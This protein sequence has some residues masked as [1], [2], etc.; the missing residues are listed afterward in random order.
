MRHGMFWCACVCSADHADEY[1]RRDALCPRRRGD[2][3]VHP[4]RGHRHR[5]PYS[6]AAHPLHRP[7]ASA[8][9]H[10][11]R[12]RCR[13]SQDDPRLLR[14]PQGRYRRRSHDARHGRLAHGDGYERRRH[15]RRVPEPHGSYG[16]LRI[17]RDV[18]PHHR[19]QGAAERPL[20][21][22]HRR[23]R[24]LRARDGAF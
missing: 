24:H 20:R 6:D 11:R 2:V 19:E 21:C 18:Q 10:S 15:V 4:R 7:A 23:Q 3:R 13:L 14:R 16:N 17:S 1:T 22:K 12:R 8:P 9:A 5:L